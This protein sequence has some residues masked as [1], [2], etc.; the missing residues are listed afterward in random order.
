LREPQNIK[1]CYHNDEVYREASI[2]QAREKI[3]ER[4]HN[5]EVYREATIEQ[6][7]QKRKEQYDNDKDY[8]NKHKK[9]VATR[10]MGRYWG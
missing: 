10:I 5:D 3:K 4:Y 7:R 2:Q 8:R 6:A 9:K 1:E